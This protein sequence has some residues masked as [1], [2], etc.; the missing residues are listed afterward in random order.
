MTGPNLSEWALGH[1]SLIVFF[2]LVC[3]VAGV[4]SYQRLGRSEDPPF[5]I[6][7][8]I[9]KVLWPGASSAEM[10]NQVTDRIEKKLEETPSLD[11]LRSYTKPGEA[12]VFV[13]LKDSTLP[14]DVP[15]IWYQVRKK[16]HDISHTLPSGVQGPYF[17]DEF[18]DTYSIIYAFTSE[19]FSYREL[20]DYVESV[21]ARLLRV[22]D[23]NKVD[24]LGVQDEKIYI[25]FSTRQIVG[26]GLVPSD[27]IRS[28]QAQNNVA[29]AGLVSTDNERILIFVSGAFGNEDDVRA[30]NLRTSSGFVRMGDVATVSRGYVDPP[31]PMF[32][33][34]G[35]LAIGLAVSM[36]KTGDVLQLGDRLSRA[37]T[38]LENDLPLGIDVHLVAD[39]PVVVDAAIHGFTKALGEAVAIV[40]A[41]SFISLGV[42]AGLV[43]AISIPLVLGM[44]FA[45]MEMLG[46][47][48]QRIS[49]G[50]LIISLGLLVDDAMITVEMMIAKL[51]EGMDRLKAA[52]F[53]YTSTAFPM[54][55]GTLVTVAGFIPVGFAK[56]AAGEY[57]NS[58]FWVVM[59][60]LIASWFVAVL[61][62]PLLG[63]WLL[64]RNLAEKRAGHGKSRFGRLPEHG[65]VASLRHRWIVIAA[66]LGLFALSLVGARFL[67][68]Q[69]FPASDRTELLVS[70]TL[71]QSSS[72]AATTK[73]V[74]RVEALMR[75]D[76]DIDRWSFYIG[77][78]A[79]RFYLPMDVQLANEF[80][81]QAVVVAKDTAARDR[82]QARLDAALKA[83][84]DDVIGRVLPLEMGPPVG[85]PI[86]YRVSG[87]DPGA[88]R[89]FAYDVGNAIATDPAVR[90]IN[91]DWNEPVKV[92]RLMI[93][94]DAA[95]LVGVTSE[96][97]ARAVRTVVSGYTVTQ[98]RD[99]TYLIDVVGRSE[100][101]ERKDMSTVRELQVILDNGKAIPLAQVATIDYTEESPLIW[102][103]KRLPTIT[104]QSDT[105]P[106]VQAATIVKRLEPAIEAERAK[107]PPGYSI[108]VGGT[109]EDSAKG[110]AS[111][112]AVV[113]VMLLAILTIL[114]LQLQSFARLALVISVAPL[115]LIG[116]VGAM[117][118]TGTPMGFI[119]TLGV[120]ALIGMI[121]RNSV[122]LIDQIEHDIAR[123]LDR[124]DA[125]I[126]AT[127]H[128]LRPILLTAAAAILGM[129]PIAHEVFWGPMA[130]AVIGGLAVATLLTLVFLPALYAV[131]FRVREP[132]VSPEVPARSPV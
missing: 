80:F 23:V 56:S 5:T 43:V 116:I 81:A 55:T 105:T 24:L 14:K 9:V 61:F 97:L 128:R 15:D 72:I 95:R 57:S 45:T 44:T 108:E 90:D 53:A 64:P 71:P 54:L 86:K 12:V 94:Q 62:A 75:A 106:G 113:P 127:L 85:F 126:D 82:V 70:L 11:Y 109:V 102:R 77:S 103:R 83:D 107:L 115:G 124:W 121:T 88:V 46:I 52:A 38:V 40:L 39:Q 2:M 93:D 17:N 20:K 48:L 89:K 19:G 37:M 42:R 132:A 73:I 29:P 68:Q 118:P 100:T 16:V 32:R 104:V 50:A 7:T 21:R 60:A 31:S 79:V 101:G 117:L 123:G 28:L 34:K 92:L 130:Y 67:Q 69:F 110:Q 63:V 122:I 6:K 18:G 1:R 3:A 98:V 8:M 114:M 51:E 84:F 33:F 30:V 78:G 35:E 99:A 119:A 65:I 49:L 10:I 4:M 59:I 87:D 125:I 58:L 76:A 112:V 41:V 74:D 66:T 111:I 26:L 27:V 120:I 91:L 47:A 22:P 96:S 25:E 13:N 129:L 131:A 36:S